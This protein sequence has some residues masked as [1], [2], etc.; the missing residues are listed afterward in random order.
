[1]IMPILG[2]FVLRAPH[3][4][5]KTGEFAYQQTVNSAKDLLWVGGHLAMGVCQS[6][7]AAGGGHPP[8]MHPVAAPRQKEYRTQ[9]ERK[10]GRVCC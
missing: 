1:M 7:G 10:A 9:I 6:C 5:R 4:G 2:S 8:R 3:P